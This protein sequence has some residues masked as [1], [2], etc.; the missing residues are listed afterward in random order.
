MHICIGVIFKISSSANKQINIH[1]LTVLLIIKVNSNYVS[2]KHRKRHFQH[3][4]NFLFLR[5]LPRNI[6]AGIVVIWLVDRSSSSRCIKPWN[7]DSGSSVMTFPDKWIKVSL[8]FAWNKPSGRL[9]NKLEEKSLRNKFRSLYF[10][11]PAHKTLP[12]F[13]P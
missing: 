10:Y 2:K 5:E 1:C 12:T 4:S 7:T 13:I 6:P 11:T 9:R 8:M 3:N